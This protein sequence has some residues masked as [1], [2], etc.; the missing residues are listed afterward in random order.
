MFKFL[1]EKLS[2]LI[3]GSKETKDI[4]ETKEAKSLKKEKKSLER[5]KKEKIKKK[6]KEE[7]ATLEKQENKEENQEKI[8]YIT[9]TGLKKEKE[10]NRLEQEIEEKAEEMEKPDSEEKIGFFSKFK[11]KF[12][13]K[14]DHETFNEFFEKLEQ[15]LLE[16]NVALSVVDKIKEDMGKDLIDI[17]IKKSDIEEE[18]KKSLKNSIQRILVNPFDIIEKIK[19]KEDEPF[20]ILFFGINGSGKTTTIAKLAHKLKKNNLSCVLAAGDTFRAAS[21]EQ[22]NKHGEKIGIK[23][24]SQDY[25]ADPTAVA[26]DAIKYAKSHGIK[27][28]LIDT[29]GRMHTKD[30]LLKEMEKII[31]VT[32]P[33]LKIFVAEAITGND[34]TEQ[35]KTFD[36]NFDIDG[37]ILTKADVDE[38]G[39]TAISVGFVT[40]K[41]ILML[42]VGQNYEDLEVFS[43]EEIISNLGLD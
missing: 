16:N 42:G 20:V 21:I 27:V 19:D 7:S 37:T 28:V 17:E 38:K 8:D 26:F 1:K 3:K 15:I 18:I 6:E 13:S 32:K 5:A 25:G 12:T 14:L 29:A 43:E 11:K 40:G 30:N 39:G 41:P 31:R 35:A 33:D 34:A 23:V 9:E 36:E 22:L 4:E 10:I 24:I 2:S